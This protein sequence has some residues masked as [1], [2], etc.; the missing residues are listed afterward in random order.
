MRWPSFKVGV[1]LAR[2]GPRWPCYEPNFSVSGLPSFFLPGMYCT[3]VLRGRRSLVV[4]KLGGEGW[5]GGRTERRISTNTQLLQSILASYMYDFLCSSLPQQPKGPRSRLIGR[6][7]TWH[8]PGL[9]ASSPT[10]LKPASDPGSSPP[11]EAVHGDH[12]GL[13]DCFGSS[14]L[15]PPIERP[16]ILRGGVP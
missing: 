6:V 5:E 14:S 13:A 11:F 2:A 4:V 15:S 3:V 16:L 7:S 12:V 8:L 9:S 1:S 10:R